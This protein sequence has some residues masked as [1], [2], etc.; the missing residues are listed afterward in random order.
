MKPK[1][2]EY[3][4]RSNSIMSKQ[5]HLLLLSFCFTLF[6]LNTQAQWVSLGSQ[7]TWWL[8]QNGYSAC[9]NN[10]DYFDTTCTTLLAA[11]SVT[12][13]S[14]NFTDL[15]F[16]QYF[17]N[18][19]YLDISDC[20]GL[21]ALPDMPNTVQHLDISFSWNITGNMNLPD[22]L[23]V[24]KCVSSSRTTL[25][26]LPL[27]LEELDCY[28]NQITQ[29]PVLP[30]T[31]K[32]LNCGVNGYLALPPVLPAGL[33]L[34]DCSSNHLTTLPAL[35][36]EISELN[37]AGNQLTALPPLPY[38]LKHF[39][40]NGNQ[41]TA[42]NNIPDSVETINCAANQ[43]T[44]LGSLSSTLK[45]L[46]CRMNNLTALPA[47]P[48][49][50]TYLDCSDNQLASLTMLPDSL[51]HFRCFRNQI[52]SMPNLPSSLNELWCWENNLSLLPALPNHISFVD[53]SS[54]PIV[55]I[56]SFP[57]VVGVFRSRNTL[58]NSLPDLPDSIYSLDVMDNPN[59]TCLPRLKSIEHLMFWNTGV[60]CLPN[61]GN[62]VSS[63]PKLD[64]I[65]LCGT[66]DTTACPYYWS[67]AGHVIGDDNSN[68][69]LDS[70]ETELG[71]IRVLVK[72]QGNV[73]A[74]VITDQR[75]TYA[76]EVINTGV[77]EVSID[78]TDL[79]FVTVCPDSAMYLLS[80]ASLDSV[81][82]NKDFG[83]RCKAGFDLEARSIAGG[84]FRPANNTTVYVT[85]GDA[86]KFYGVTCAAGTGGSVTLTYTGPVQFVSAA[87]GA[88]TPTLSGNTLTWSVADFGN[89]NFFTA[90]NIIMHTDTNAQIEGEVC[91]T[92]TVNPIAG[93]NNPTNNVLNFCFPIV[94][95][96]DPNDK[97]AY[98]AGNMDTAQKELT[99]TI[100]FQ[101]TG[102]AE[103]QHIYITDTL[104]S[105]VDASTFQ[106]LA[107]SH[108]P[109][110][111]L[112]ENAVR[113]NFPNINL[114]DSNTNEPASHGYVQYKVKLK[115]NLPVGTVINNTAYIYF[116]FNAPVITNTTTNT[117][118]L[119]TGIATLPT[120]A[121]SFTLYPN[122]ASNSVTISIPESLIGSTATV[123]DVMGRV[124]AAVPLTTGNTQLST[125]DLGSGIYF[126]TLGNRTQ[127]LIIHH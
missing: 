12:I 43:L 112:K 74:S 64:T 118:S 59:L 79:P 70:N 82:T 67:I 83:L 1:V 123:S 108:Q 44:S 87:N 63:S 109:M 40:C 68:C 116:D 34:L 76:Y 55:S 88:L 38:A 8:K 99:Y 113:F 98:P 86:A 24:F 122:P 27:Y 51:V 49:G 2:H 90:F 78:T 37:V 115:P 23:K 127:K 50:L 3:L 62:V 11:D 89:V 69:H 94:N 54:N 71:G 21:N 5:V 111:Q 92:L 53:C 125:H 105:D 120:A 91:F 41:L 114:P 25:P 60:N 93:D 84:I 65:P 85:A 96:Y 29:L 33:T 20:G 4:N 66:Y 106:L 15:P 17:K 42:L 124:V 100:R 103:A 32:V 121:A 72:Q 81:A 101:N 9:F 61:Y 10:Q 77:Y 28:N 46:D 58:L 39:N 119:N 22:S 110:V 26:T 19:K 56:T 126:I 102:T 47:L 16:L 36:M 35:P 97:T 48:T 7:S 107:Y 30:A 117:I 80:I 6:S 14:N 75:G 13:H 95:S 31:L 73:V 18:L 57:P 52:L 45:S 104:D